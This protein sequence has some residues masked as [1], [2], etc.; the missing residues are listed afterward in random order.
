MIWH[1]WRVDVGKE[2]PVGLALDSRGFEAL[3]PV[4]IRWVRVSRYAKRRERR[5]YALLPGYVLVGFEGGVPWDR[6]AR[7]RA[8]HR[9]VTFG[10]RP[11]IIPE[12]V[13][14]RLRDMSGKALPS[15]VSVN[16][17]RAFAAGDWVRITGRLSDYEAQVEAIEGRTARVRLPILGQETVTVN[18]DALEAA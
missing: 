13:I 9:P 3:V 16:T 12:A 10:G 15:R 7:I 1:A 4:E 14:E 8:L 18:L 6:M 2:I 17:R 11:S 5:D